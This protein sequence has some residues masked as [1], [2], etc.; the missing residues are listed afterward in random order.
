VKR[1]VRRGPDVQYTYAID[2]VREAMLVVVANRPD[3]WSWSLYAPGLAP[4]S[5]GKLVDL[6]PAPGRAQRWVV[7][8]GALSGTEVYRASNQEGLLVVESATWRDAH[9]E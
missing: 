2:G 1:K 4:T 5:L 7:A 3:A 6:P 9:T 8:D